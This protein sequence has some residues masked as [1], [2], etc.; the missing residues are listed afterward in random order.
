MRNSLLILYFLNRLYA[1]AYPSADSLFIIE[2]KI[3]YYNEIPI[4][5]KIMTDKIS[6]ESQL[7]ILKYSENYESSILVNTEGSITSDPECIEL[8]LFES[9]KEPATIIYLQVNDNE[10]L[11]TLS[12]C[13]KKKFTQYLININNYQLHSS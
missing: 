3:L 12:K 2:E 8:D 10:S 11:I 4:S 13:E 1:L 5:L 6:L 7:E 9:F